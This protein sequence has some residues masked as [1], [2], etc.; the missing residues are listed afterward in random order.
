MTN[1][2]LFAFC[3]DV[4]IASKKAV[5]DGE[6]WE[7]V[8]ERDR[9]IGDDIEFAFSLKKDGNEIAVMEVRFDMSSCFGD[10]AFSKR[11]NLINS[12]VAIFDNGTLHRALKASDITFCKL[13]DLFDPMHMIH[14]GMNAEVYYEEEREKCI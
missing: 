2:E 8:P 7:H 12:G 10:G 13:E 5:I 9:M 3:K 11:H 14:F 6:H 1:F 4:L